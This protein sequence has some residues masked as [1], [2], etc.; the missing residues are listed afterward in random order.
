V[1]AYFYDKGYLMG[2]CHKAYWLG[3]NASS[4]GGWLPVDKTLPSNLTANYT[5]WGQQIPDYY[6][7]PFFISGAARQMLC[8]AANGSDP[9]IM[10]NS[11]WSWSNAFCNLKNAAMCRV[12]R[13]WP[14]TRRLLL[15]AAMGAG[16]LAA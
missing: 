7:F 8:V 9:S 5:L 1:E 16:C 14:G 11:T 6:P 3:Y 2:P 15:A 13:G 10:I 12:M 4:F